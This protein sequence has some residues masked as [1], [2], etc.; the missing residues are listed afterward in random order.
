MSFDDID[1]YK[2]LKN[3]RKNPNIEISN[4]TSIRKLISE[5]ETINFQQELSKLKKFEEVQ[6]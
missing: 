1:K 3:E 6:E 4:I 2:Q 5:Y